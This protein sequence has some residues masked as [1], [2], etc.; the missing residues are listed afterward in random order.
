[1]VKALKS[2]MLLSDVMYEREAQKTLKER[3]EQ[4]EKEITRHWEEI[5]VEKMR[6]YDD[7]M[8]AKLEEEYRVKMH[9]AQQIS[10]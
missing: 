2:K 4:H 5:E 8:R 7:K 10:D 6:E 9:N 3:K 1:M